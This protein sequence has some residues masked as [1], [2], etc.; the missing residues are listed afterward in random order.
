MRSNLHGLQA[1]TTGVM[2]VLFFG[3]FFSELDLWPML[4]ARSVCDESAHE[5]ARVPPYK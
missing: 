2:F 3:K 5:A 4:Y 1:E